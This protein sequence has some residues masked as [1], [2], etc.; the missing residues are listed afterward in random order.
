MGMRNP[1]I[2]HGGMGVV[3]RALVRCTRCAFIYPGPG[4]DIS[5]I[6]EI[7]WLRARRHRAHCLSHAPSFRFAM[8]KH[9]TA[10][11]LDSMQ[12]W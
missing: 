9:L 12:A 11:E 4:S 5:E 3:M 10:H 1:N 6:G 8:G 7:V 2:E